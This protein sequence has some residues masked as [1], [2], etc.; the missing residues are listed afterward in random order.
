LEFSPI[1]KPFTTTEKIL[2]DQTE[3]YKDHLIVPIRIDF[4][5]SD[6]TVKVAFSYVTIDQHFQYVQERD[7][8]CG[9]DAAIA[10]AKKDIDY[11]EI[12]IKSS[13]DCFA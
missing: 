9:F 10:V 2:F 12:I 1:K 13:F 8:F 3:A 4:T 7:Q 5:Y 6:R 11:R